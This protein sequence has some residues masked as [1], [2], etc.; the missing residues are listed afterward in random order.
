MAVRKP[1][2]EINLDIWDNTS[3]K[4]KYP[5]LKLPILRGIVNFVEM[6][7]YGYR[8]LMKS[9]EI[10]G[11]DE[12]EEKK[13]A[14][15]KAA[16]IDEK[17]SEKEIVAESATIN[18][19]VEATASKKE[20]TKSESNSLGMKL[21]LWGASIVGIVFAVFIF[22]FI[23]TWAISAI[24]KNLLHLGNLKTLCEGIL[25]IIIF[26]A[27][28]A[29]VGLSKD[30]RRVYEYHGA[31]HKSIYCYEQEEELTVENA[32]KF[33]RLHPR[34]GTS[35]ILI[36]IIISI[37]IFSLPFIPWDNTLLRVAIHLILLPIVVGISYEIIKF[38]GSHDKLMRIVLAPGLWL[39]YFTTREP[40]DSQLEVALMSLKAVMT[41]NKED[42]KW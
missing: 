38:A 41:D 25:K 29:V 16:K 14:E 26:V 3:V 17:A 11:F 33:T 20:D 37:I 22:M 1:D 28:L 12:E 7:V 8:C 2:G 34:C 5:V 9:A 39:Q 31:E 19:P 30:I 40:D 18:E 35:F 32:R 4:D 24:D 15:A 21:V 6:L 42:D 23:P 36:V 10:S 27:Y 13:K